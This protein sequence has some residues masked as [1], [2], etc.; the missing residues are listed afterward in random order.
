MAISQ[1]RLYFITLVVGSILTASYA[2][3]F[4]LHGAEPNSSVITLWEFAFLVLLV[5]WVEQDSKR[6]AEIYHPFEFG[7]LVLI[8]WIPYL[9]FYLFRTRGPKGIAI[10]LGFLGLICLPYFVPWLVYA[11]R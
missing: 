11:G 7:F 4:Y 3:V 10:F 5:L 2:A 8:F 6:R 1:Q 9:P